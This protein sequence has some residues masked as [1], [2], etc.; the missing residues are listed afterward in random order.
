VR[1]SRSLLFLAALLA[2]PAARAQYVARDLG[3][4]GGTQSAAVAIS[5]DGRVVGWSETKDGQSHASSGR[6]SAG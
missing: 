5:A 4:L 6:R 2:A 1:S 3:T